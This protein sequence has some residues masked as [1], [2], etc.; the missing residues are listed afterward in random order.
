M[1]ISRRFFLSA[2][3]GAAAL[4]Y[5][6]DRLRNSSRPVIPSGTILST[7]GP[8]SGPLYYIVAPNEEALIDHKKVSANPNKAEWRPTDYM[9]ITK[10]QCEAKIRER[11]EV[12]MG[13]GSSD[14]SPQRIVQIDITNLRRCVRVDVWDPVEKYSPDPKDVFRP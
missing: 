9:Q 1:T 13:V 10:K 2:I 8:A 5:T 6:A 3:V 14:G 11:Y 12:H 7:P 4:G